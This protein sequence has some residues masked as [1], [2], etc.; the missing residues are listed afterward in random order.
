MW[1]SSGF[2]LFA[3]FT[4][5]MAKS[6]AAGTGDKGFAWSFAIVFMAYGIALITSGALGESHILHRAGFVALCLV[7]YAT[8]FDGT[9]ASWLLTS[10]WPTQVAQPGYP[11]FSTCRD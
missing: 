3:Y 2:A 10:S 1:Q 5:L 11:G 4:T 9:A 8:W 6:F 7:P